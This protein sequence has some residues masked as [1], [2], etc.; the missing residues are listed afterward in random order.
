VGS[1]FLNVSL[2]TVQKYNVYSPKILCVILLQCLS[3]VQG[4]SKET[5]ISKTKTSS[6]IIDSQLFSDFLNA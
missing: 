1:F 5:S 4:Q 3:A 2:L 6:L